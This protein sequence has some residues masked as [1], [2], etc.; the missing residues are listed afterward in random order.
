MIV[1][2][3]RLSVQTCTAEWVGKYVENLEKR[4]GL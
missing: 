4:R 1:R 2:I 3:I